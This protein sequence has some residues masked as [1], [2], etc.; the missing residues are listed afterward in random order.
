MALVVGTFSSV[1]YV[2]MQLEARRRLYPEV[3][4]LI[5]DDSSPHAAELQRL[6][7]QYGA[8]FTS[9]SGRRPPTLGDLQ[10]L[11]RGICWAHELGA[12]ILVKLSRRF[13]PLVDWTGDLASLWRSSGHHTFTNRTESFG[14][15]F[16]S[17][18][19]AVDVRSWATPAVVGEMAFA[20]GGACPVFVEGFLHDLSRRIEYGLASK[21]G[22]AP[23]EQGYVPWAFM[24]VDRCAKYDA[25]LWHD[26]SA[27]E[28]YEAKAVSW[29]LSYPSES[30][31]DPNGGF[32]D[33]AGDQ[34]G[35]QAYI[36]V[37]KELASHLPHKGL[38]LE[39]GVGTG[40]SFVEIAPLFDRAVGVDDLGRFS[41]P[42][43]DHIVATTDAFFADC[44]G[45][46][47]DLVFID[48]CHEHGQVMRDVE[49]ALRIIRPETGI[50][51]IHDTYPPDVGYVESHLC[52]SAWRA[53]D[54]LRS[55]ALEFGIEVLTLPID[56]GVTLVRRPSRGPR[57]W[58][59]S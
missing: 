44:D 28:E 35:G 9:T 6:C 14:F 24:G 56:C 52:W 43:G 47:A 22:V 39:L 10:A 50:I 49:N 18:C 19:V 33:G 54:Q 29:G 16:R 41:G 48:A 59:Q 5:H 37:L 30:Y 57:R 38:Y 21:R 53:A 32:G 13:V 4:M 15:G 17:E 7:S 20:V 45:F 55:R 26:S 23:L 34:E 3:P 40:E 8:H 12:D 1:P 58:E 42:P 11:L 31:V 27:P 25:F 2:H 36:E 51:A 46:E